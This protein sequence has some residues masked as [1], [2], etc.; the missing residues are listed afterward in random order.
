MSPKL[1][2]PTQQKRIMNRFDYLMI[3]LVTTFVN[4]ILEFIYLISCWEYAAA[5]TYTHIVII[6][7]IIIEDFMS[8]VVSTISII[9]ADT[10]WA[11]NMIAFLKFAS[12]SLGILAMGP[13]TGEK[14]HARFYCFT[15]SF[16]LNIGMLALSI[17]E[18]VRNIRRDGD[19]PDV[20]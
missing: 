11:Y 10:L 4:I 7:A 14:I 13:E 1:T 20:N 18:G 12:V 5:I 9:W 2:G 17:V 3:V 6:C 16:V 15:L 8:M 19:G